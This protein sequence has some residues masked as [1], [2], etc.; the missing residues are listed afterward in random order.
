M[1]KKLT[2]FLFFIISY[3]SFSQTLVANFPFSNS[4]DD[5]QNAINMG[6]N[7]PNPSFVLDRCGVAS[8]AM[9]FA[10]GYLDKGNVGVLE[11]NKGVTLS[12]WVKRSSNSS[13]IQTIASKADNS[14]S[15]SV[16]GYTFGFD[17]NNKLFASI[18]AENMS[19]TLG[20]TFSTSADI[21]NLN[22]WNYVTY[23]F[24]TVTGHLKG[25]INGVLVASAAGVNF[26]SIQ[27][28]TNSLFTIG[29]AAG[30]ESWKFRGSLDEIRIYD[31]E[32]SESQV[33]DLF[34]SYTPFISVSGITNIGNCEKGLVSLS[35]NTLIGGS[36]QFGWLYNNSSITSTNFNGASFSGLNLNTLEILNPNL[37][38]N[39]V[40]FR[41]VVRSGCGN[42][43]TSGFVLTVVPQTKGFHSSNIINTCVGSNIIIPLTSISGKNNIFSWIKDGVTISSGNYSNFNTSILGISSLNSTNSGFYQCVIN[44]DC[45][46]FTTSGVTLNVN[47][48]TSS[49]LLSNVDILTCVGESLSFTSNSISG[50]NLKYNWLANNQLITS[51]SSSIYG[52]SF[53]TTSLNISSLPL[54]FN[55]YISLS[56]SGFCGAI[57]L[58]GFNLKS[59]PF[60]SAQTF[61][62]QNLETCTGSNF[63]LVPL[64][65]TGFNNQYFWFK[66]V[67]LITST[68]EPYIYGSSYNTSSLGFNNIPNTL[69]GTFSLSVSG[70]CGGFTLDGFNLVTRDL[71]NIDNNLSISSLQTCV[72]H[73]FV[74]QANTLSGYNLKYNWLRNDVPIQFGDEAGIYGSSFTTLG[75]NLSNITNGLNFDYKLSVTGFCGS[76][77]TNFSNIDVYE[78]TSIVGIN[79]LLE[80]CPG[81]TFSINVSTISG[82]DLKFSWFKNNVLIDQFT[83]GGLH[84][85]SFTSSGL[86][87]NNITIEGF[88]ATYQVSVSGF[89]SVITSAGYDLVVRSITS[90]GMISS[91][92]LETCPGFS[93]GIDVNT[94]KGHNLK[95]QWIKGSTPI[96]TSTD[97]GIYG[98]TFTTTG[99]QFNNIFSGLSSQYYLSV[100][101]YCG[102]ATSD[103][104]NLITRSNTSI[105]GIS[106]VGNTNYC[107]GQTRVFVFNTV[108]GHNNQIKWGYNLPNSFV[109][110]IEASSMPGV[111]IPFNMNALSTTITSLNAGFNNTIL[112]SVTGFCNSA[113][114]TLSGLN[115]LPN[116][117]Q[118]TS[119]TDLT[120]CRGTL[121]SFVTSFDGNNLAY[122]WLVKKNG[123]LN[124]TVM[125]NFG[126]VPGVSSFNT[127]TGGNLNTL[128]VR[129]SSGSTSS[130]TINNSF[131][132]I[133]VNGTCGSFINTILGNSLSVQQGIDISQVPLFNI[134]TCAGTTIPLNVVA[135][136]TNITYEW[137]RGITT[138][139]GI[140]LSTSPDASLY[141]SSLTTTSLIITNIPASISG[142]NY[143]LI[144]GSSCGTA[145]TSGTV[146]TIRTVSSFLVNP[147]S[148][149]TCPG[150]DTF[151]NIS[152]TSAPEYPNSYI[153]QV[154]TGTGFNN[155]SDG[156]VY[157]NSATTTLNLNKIPS[158]FSGYLFRNIVTNSCGSTISSNASYTSRQVPFADFFTLKSSYCNNNDTEILVSAHSANPN[159]GGQFVSTPFISGLLTTSGLSAGRVGF[160]PY[161]LTTSG[162]ISVTYLSPPNAFGCVSTVTYSTFV[163]TVQSVFFTE[164]VLTEYVLN[165]TEII[166]VLAFPTSP[167]T[168]KL[169][170]K[171]VVGN[172]IYINLVSTVPGIFPIKY[173]FTN[174]LTGCKSS[175]FISLSI[176][177]IERF[178]ITTVGIDARPTV[179]GLLSKNSFCISDVNRYK[180]AYQGITPESN[181][182]QFIA[183]RCAKSFSLLINGQPTIP[184]ISTSSY[185]LPNVNGSRYDISN[186]S[187]VPSVLGVGQFDI[188]YAFD[189]NT[190]NT[191]N[192]NNFLGRTSENLGTAYNIEIK[193]LSPIPTL[194]VDTL[195]FCEY[196]LLNQSNTAINVVGSN[197]K[198][199]ILSI[200]GSNTITSELLFFNPN[201]VT[202]GEIENKISLLPKVDAPYRFKITQNSNGCTSLS[203]EFRLWIYPKP[204]LPTIS[205]ETINNVICLNSNP[206]VELVVQTVSGNTIFNWYE[207]NSLVSQNSNRYSPLIVTNAPITRI[208]ECKKSQFGCES[209]PLVFNVR[210]FDLP[211]NPTTDA[212][213]SYCQ[214]SITG[215]INALNVSVVGLGVDLYEDIDFIWYQNDFNNIIATTSGILTN[216]GANKLYSSSFV[217]S[218][219]TNT[220][221]SSNFI[222]KSVYRNNRCESSSSSNENIIINP[223]PTKPLIERFGA[224]SG[225]WNSN[226]FIQSEVCNGAQ[227]PSFRALG[228]INSIYKWYSDAALNNLV[229]EQNEITPTTSG[230]NAKSINFFLT[231][232]VENCTSQSE[233]LTINVREQLPKPTVIFP[234]PGYFCA[235]TSTSLISTT[236]ISGT[237][238]GFNWYSSPDFNIN[239]LIQSSSS[240]TFSPPASSVSNTVQYFVKQ[241]SGSCES[242]SVIVNVVYRPKPN[243]VSIRD[244]AYCESS[245]MPRLFARSNENNPV[246][247]WYT[248]TRNFLGNGLT[249]IIGTNKINS[250]AT[251][252]V[253][254]FTGGE[255]ST[256]NPYG[257]YYVSQVVN[258]CE[259]DRDS[260][261]VYLVKKPFIPTISI[262]NDKYCSGSTLANATGRGL[263]NAS[264]TWYFNNNFSNLRGNTAVQSLNSLSNTI[265]WNS[266][267]LDSLV[268]N[269]HVRQMGY[270]ISDPGKINFLGCN[271]DFQTQKIII[272][273]NPPAPNASS[274]ITY[275]GNINIA[276]PNLTASGFSR[277]ISTLNW[278]SDS[279]SINLLSSGNS[280][281]PIITDRNP[282]VSYTTNFYVNQTVRNC[283]SK[284]R[285]I[286]IKIN[287]TPVIN[288]SGLA[289]AYCSNNSPVT[290]TGSVSNEG[291]F[292]SNSINATRGIN[293]FRTGLAQ[294]SPAQAS[295]SVGSY[296]ISYRYTNSFGCT[297][298]VSKSVKINAEPVVNF[299]NNGSEMPSKICVNA[300]P[301]ILIGT[302]PNGTFT[303]PGTSFDVSTNRFKP[304]D[305]GIGFKN[306]Y[307]SF[308]SSEGCS[309][310][311]NFN[312]DIR[313]LPTVEFEAENKCIEDSISF[314][315]LSSVAGGNIISNFWIVENG[316]TSELKNPK[317][318][319]DEFGSYVVRLNA[320]SNDNCTNFRSKSFDLG[321]S[322]KIGFSISRICEGDQTQFNNFTTLPIT[323]GNITNYVW[324]IA[325]TVISNT[326]SNFVYAFN[327]P[328]L[329]VAKVTV[330]SD[331]GCKSDSTFEI[332]IAPKYVANAY[333]YA[334][335][336]DDNTLGWYTAGT[337]NSWTKGNFS[338]SYFN[339]G[340]VTGY[341]STGGNSKY[342]SSENSFVYSPCF[343]F[344]QLS[345]PMLSMSFASDNTRGGDGALVQYTLNDGQNWITLGERNSGLSW[346]N[347]S[348]ITSNPGNQENFNLGW[349]G[350]LNSNNQVWQIARHRLD[351]LTGS[352]RVQFR[353]AFSSLEQDVTQQGFAFDNFVLG[354][355]SQNV[356]L[357]NF[358]NMNDQNSNEVIELI[359]DKKSEKFAPDV[360]RV[361]YH[362]NFPYQNEFNGNNSFDISSRVLY[363]GVN[364]VPYSIVNG[365]RFNNLSS[366]LSDSNIIK[367]SLKYP[368]FD[369]TSD[370][371]IVDNKVKADVKLKSL[372]EYGNDNSQLDVQVLVVERDLT[373]IQSLTG[374]TSFDYVARKFLP[375]ASGNQ[376][377]GKWLKDETKNTISLEWEIASFVKNKDNLG[378]V[379]F[380]QDNETKEVLQSNYYGPNKYV[381]TVL[382]PITKTDI[383]IKFDDFGIYPNPASH[384][385]NICLISN[386]ENIKVGIMK[387]FVM[388][389]LLGN[390]VKT[391]CLNF[392]EGNHKLNISD[393]SEGVYFMKIDHLIKKVIVRNY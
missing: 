47:Y 357:E 225:T 379:I 295:D 24:T 196:D 207:S 264:F 390:V 139:S 150:Y 285:N 161:I 80:T 354:S 251:S 48:N 261:K 37:S 175:D 127:F 270:P 273:P 41:S 342:N 78:N 19:S 334:A 326:G 20:F 164:P 262:A 290:L 371:S 114:S 293:N 252:W 168:G 237:T 87:F 272:Y 229:Y 223:I 300:D 257:A 224:I 117:L 29:D 11:L 64:S 86:S 359:L 336:F 185:V 194:S 297:N 368:L 332:N 145:T 140:K 365:N 222:V 57:S 274:S 341:W 299:T 92:S 200:V 36:F 118:L 323:A 363:Y 84:S 21:I 282:S 343:D 349:S 236:G 148:T 384:N 15:T 355:R 211:I 155:I 306:I 55:N 219:Y 174:T 134:T 8:S 1:K 108:S 121:A 387:D 214:T 216:L 42:I 350:R 302:P 133:S 165:S 40:N 192:C 309:S 132:A 116:T 73:D 138:S 179:N 253:F 189:Y 39:G 106:L 292:F 112:V 199:Y 18:R 317:F 305:A 283:V 63:N 147:I 238:I 98:N 90:I 82:Y 244:T 221:G 227:L 28:Q 85:N 115:Q 25:Y 144:M 376:F 213:N 122:R 69:L 228:Q 333:P 4:E 381:T 218:F 313:P 206:I 16:S 59:V 267:Q 107:E 263:L 152:T 268:H 298:S 353:V 275:C 278:Y 169:S 61:N 208:F 58:S 51:A 162:S 27:N 340:N 75:L 328:G 137:Y 7:A 141:G 226:S 44:G 60:S 103:G 12:A 43:T 146:F 375:D 233:K 99:L 393:L 154:N 77:S 232:T 205:S 188:F 31:D 321:L 62:L 330:Y 258:G 386:K 235:G 316:F 303:S 13:T 220:L 284:N 374:K 97:G 239:S 142:L 331:R 312:I 280:Y 271:S 46:V 111:G 10:G 197:I 120:R 351:T 307:Y 366:F 215:L 318:S 65:L 255:G 339:Q 209:D 94:L 260:I 5:I 348:N 234:N 346:Y 170:G 71:T 153:W 304:L 50:F 136:A 391:G 130:S 249:T 383:N 231:Q 119:A 230:V 240:K 217:P 184:G 356:L 129:I 30:T 105:S 245:N 187:I 6:F 160:N 177:N 294:F 382:G 172:S 123:S 149:S 210:V 2:L 320:T 67:N 347:E 88:N 32:L 125:P 367:S 204:I 14:S 183:G 35:V 287:P 344:T 361:D 70:Y 329:K 315:N 345:K 364:N 178:L 26:L 248:N 22:E 325:E 388:F 74:I 369:I 33:V 181:P 380:V 167:G 173:E 324:D 53:T 286:F 109:A 352:Q 372:Y 247:R 9:T 151:F 180:L 54:N 327:S 389:D 159:P 176:T 110:F 259:S 246:F 45:G 182:G 370:L 38:L 276:N 34:N 17:Q 308:T 190:I 81:T 265:S 158:S 49:S 93:F 171:G 124:W 242:D 131:Y 269:I 66:N 95:Y 201:A 392:S 203:T 360:I 166:P 279:T 72:G 79:Y 250:I 156:G 335:T 3:S 338:N 311:T 377:F 281:T 52:N 96:S 113:F 104:F 288:F 362:T 241:T 289:T 256:S 212:I 163:N 314:I 83:D 277:A 135:D 378:V 291:K 195:K 358:V 143:F 202:I 266:N 373:N 310:S 186:Y 23:T 89:C 337:N 126:P 102:I 198:W 301:L 157:L 193:E 191:P 243:K 56:V 91:T 76:Q 100:S 319:F 68:E 254:T 101:G 385:V 128:D 322:P 296:D